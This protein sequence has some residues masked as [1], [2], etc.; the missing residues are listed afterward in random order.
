M[1]AK[2]DHL[3]TLDNLLWESQLLDKSLG[4]SSIEIVVERKI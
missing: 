1:E 3:A 2:G 4:K